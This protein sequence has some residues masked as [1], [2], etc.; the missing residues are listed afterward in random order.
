MTPGEH[1]LFALD[2]CVTLLPVIH[3]SGD[4]ALRV[5]QIL[6]TDRFSALAVP[7]PASFED[8]TIEGVRQLPRI[9]VAVAEEPTDPPA[10]S[11]VPIDPCQPVIM[12]IRLATQEYMPLHFID[13]ETA[14]YE[15]EAYI[16]PDP[17]SVKIASLDRFCAAL[18]PA[19]PQP[20]PGSQTQRRI[21]YMA[22]RLHE[23]REERERVLCLCALHHWPWLRDA[24]RRDAA[25]AETDAPRYAPVRLSPVREKS[26]AFV[27]GELPYITYLYEKARRE[28]EPDENLS[29]DGV[30]SLLIEAREEW[31]RKD[32]PVINWATPQ[33][34]RILAHYAR[35]LT[36]MRARLTPDLFTLAL[37]A[38]QVIG[39]GY[40]IA[41]IE[42]AK[43]YPFQ[44]DLP[45]S[46]AFGP[47]EGSFPYGSGQVKNRL[48]GQPISWRNLPLRKQPDAA[49]QQQ[50]KQRW[51]PYGICSWP[52]EDHRIESLNTHA[53]DAAKA[54]LGAGLARAEKF[55][56]SLKDGLDLR[57]SLRHWYEGTLYVKELPPVR[58]DIDAV[59]FLFDAPADHEKYN[60]RTSWYAEHE[61]EST[62]S[63]YATPIGEKLIGPGIAE[64]VY[65]GCLFLFPPRWIPDIWEDR[66]LRA[67]TN[68][69]ERLIA[70]ACLHSSHRQVALVSYRPPLSTWKL[71]ARRFRKKLIHVPMSRFS[72][73]TL[74]R[75]RVFHVLNGKSVRSYAARFIREI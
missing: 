65:G 26:L 4:F 49:Q 23:L 37:S 42:T 43:Q 40:A 24:Y 48:Q 55:S 67:L 41:L 72:S 35:N 32:S 5:R 18:L 38:Q 34:L 51:N 64:C 44:H 16:S 61:E 59:V 56:T 14:V 12:A 57:E 7:L 62:L 13:M 25:P 29:I 10:F 63:F 11:Y 71:I 15:E 39:D 9:S 52:P 69:E 54:L 19:I 47:N 21:S 6:L 27:L 46:A 58:G 60:W 33:R 3:G 70:G 74:E 68:L 31:L 17:Y 53:R 66:R 45:D 28:L 73:D 2:D 50:W 20:R 30:K 75:L 36:L 22:R 1:A 8:A